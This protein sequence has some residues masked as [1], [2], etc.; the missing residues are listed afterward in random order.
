MSGEVLEVEPVP[1]PMALDLARR[2][3]CTTAQDLCRKS[4]AVPWSG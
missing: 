1:C 2:R 4:W 3:K